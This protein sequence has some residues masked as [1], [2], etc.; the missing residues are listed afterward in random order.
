MVYPQAPIKM[1]IYMELVQGIR[2]THGNSKDHVL[3][4][5][6]KM[7]GRKQARLVWNSFLVDKLMSVGFTPLLIHNCVFFHNDI[8]FMVYMYHGIFLGSNDLQLQDII[9]EIQDLL[10][11]EDQSHPSDYVGVN[12]KKLKDDS[13][14]FSY[15]ST[16]MA[17]IPAQQGRRRQCND[18]D[19]ASALRAT[20]PAQQ[21]QQGQCNNGDN[22]SATK[23]KKPA[24]W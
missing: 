20:M 22:A 16:I 15:A 5:E 23:A 6:K 19:N 14:E 24:Q 2:T 13:F 12:I 8:I 17:K 21:W 9:K 3:K 7:Y 1:N 11:I 10:N 4:L 18:G